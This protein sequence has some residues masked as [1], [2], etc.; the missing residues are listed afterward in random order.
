MGDTKG[1]ERFKYHKISLSDMEIKTI[2]RKWGSSIAVIIPREV[3]DKKRIKENEEIIMEVKKR[4]LA[5]ELFGVLSG[6]KKSG[7]ELK[8]EM[9]K[10]W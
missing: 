8:D 9:R 7:Q 10:G 2:A 6:I 5:S 3:A 1:I 4:P